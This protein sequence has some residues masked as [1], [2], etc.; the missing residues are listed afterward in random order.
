[1]IEKKLEIVEWRD[2]NFE[3]FP[4]ED[5]DSDADYIVATVGWVEEKEL[6]LVVV[7]EITPGGERAVTRIPKQNVLSRRRLKIKPLN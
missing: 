3:F 2:A 1:M 6:W 4:D 5:F 7:G